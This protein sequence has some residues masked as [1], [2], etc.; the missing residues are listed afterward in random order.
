M[1]SS[2][3]FLSLDILLC[4]VPRLSVWHE[5]SILANGEYNDFGGPT[6]AQHC[7]RRS[8]WHSKLVAV[9]AVGGKRRGTK[10]DVPS[11]PRPFR[12]LK[13]ELKRKDA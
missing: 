10:T 2:D 12:N 9:G 3:R 6:K 11:S 7:W 5:R 4:T 8:Q 1:R 13:E